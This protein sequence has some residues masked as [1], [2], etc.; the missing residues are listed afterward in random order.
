M[1]DATLPP[2]HVN[3]AMALRF[4]HIGPEDATGPPF[5][6]AIGL[7]GG[8]TETRWLVTPAGLQ[9][10]RAIVRRHGVARSPGHDVAGTFAVSM[11]GAVVIL[12]PA[13]MRLVLRALRCVYDEARLP[14][15]AMLAI[16]ENLLAGA[17]R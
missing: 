7:P 3:T 16:Q 14:G 6:V 2:Q 15:P 4:E 8:S 11:D 12:P 10:I 13:G 9:T 1:A 17:R 5:T